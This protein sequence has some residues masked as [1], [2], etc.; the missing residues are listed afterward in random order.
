MFLHYSTMSPTDRCYRTDSIR[1]M[2]KTVFSTPM[3]R[4]GATDARQ[5]RNRDKGRVMVGPQHRPIID[6]IT[7]LPNLTA[8]KAVLGTVSEGSEGL[9]EQQEDKGRISMD[10][11]LIFSHED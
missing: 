6:T 11:H 4:L 3:E 7:H 2:T 8:H 5:N 1:Q 9:N 10:S